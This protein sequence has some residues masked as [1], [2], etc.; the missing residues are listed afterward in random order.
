MYFDDSH[1]AVKVTDVT[2]CDLETKSILKPPKARAP[3]QEVD[4]GNQITVEF[5]VIRKRR[6]SFA[7]VNRIKEFNSE[8]KSFS[9][10]STPAYEE[11][12]STSSDS[13]ALSTSVSSNINSLTK[14]NDITILDDT[15]DLTDL[16]IVQQSAMDITGIK[17]QKPQGLPDIFAPR[18][19]DTDLFSELSINRPVFPFEINNQNTKEGLEPNPLQTK[20]EN[21]PEDAPLAVDPRKMLLNELLEESA[22]DCTVDNYLKPNTL[23][24]QNT[25]NI[26]ENKCELK[27]SPLEVSEMDFTLAFAEP[28]KPESHH[29]LP[30]LDKNYLDSQ[31]K[32]ENVISNN[33]ANL[34]GCLGMDLEQSSRHQDN[35]S[36][37]EY[38]KPLQKPKKNLLFPNFDGDE[39]KATKIDASQMEFTEVLSSK[40]LNPVE[41]NLV[42]SNYIGD[43]LIPRPNTSPIDQLNP[44]LTN[45]KGSMNFNSNS[46]ESRL[47]NSNTSQM[48]FTEAL[49]PKYKNVAT[50]NYLENNVINRP[51]ISH[52]K[53]PEPSQNTIQSNM[54]PNSHI[55]TSRTAKSNDASQMEFTEVL[56]SKNIGQLHLVANN[57]ISTSVSQ[58]ERQSMP[59]YI[60]SNDV[61][62]MEFTEVLPS[63]NIGHPNPVANNHIIT[64]DSEMGRQSIPSHVKSN[65]ASQMEF[66]EVLP[67]KNIGQLNLVANN[68]ISTSV[69]Q[70]G[71]QSLPS[72]I[73]SN[74]ASHMEFTEVLPSKN[75]DHPNSVANNHIIT[76]DS[77]MG[78]PSIPSHVKSNDASQMEFTEVLPSKNIGC[79]N[80]V[81][82]IRST[83]TVSQI[84]QS[85][86]FEKLMPSYG[87]PNFN[88]DESRTAKSNNASQMELTEALPPKILASPTFNI[89]ESGLVKNNTTQMELTEALPSQNVNLVNNY[90]AERM[91]DR[92]NNSRLMP[93]KPS[94]NKI[95]N[96]IIPSLKADE[97]KSPYCPI[98]S[99]NLP[100]NNVVFNK[101]PESRLS[102]HS[103]LSQM[104]D[105]KVDLNSEKL[106]SNNHPLCQV[107][108]SFLGCSEKVGETSQMELTEAVPMFNKF[109]RRKS[110]SNF[111]GNSGFHKNS[112]GINIIVDRENIPP[113]QDLNE[114]DAMNITELNFADSES[115]TCN[116]R[117]KSDAKVNMNTTGLTDHSKPTETKF[118]NVGDASNMEFTEGLP[119]NVLKSAGKSEQK[120]F[121]NNEMTKNYAVPVSVVDNILGNSSCMEFTSALPP[122]KQP[123]KNESSS[124]QNVKSKDE[125]SNELNVS[126]TTDITEIDQH[127]IV[128]DIKKNE[129]VEVNIKRV[130]TQQTLNLV[131]SISKDLSQMEFT[132]ALPSRNIQAPL[133]PAKQ[134]NLKCETSSK[135]V[136][137]NIFG[138]NYNLQTSNMEFTEVLPM[139][140]SKQA[141]VNS[142]EVCEG[143]SVNHNALQNKMI[144][145]EQNLN[146]SC[147]MDVTDVENVP[148]HDIFTNLVRS[149]ESSDKKEVNV[150]SS[151]CSDIPRPEIKDSLGEEKNKNSQNFPF[152][153]GSQ[154]IFVPEPKTFDALKSDFS[155]LE[156]T[157]VLP[158]RNELNAGQ[159]TQ[160]IFG[161]ENPFMNKR[162]SIVASHGNDLLGSS[163]MEFTEFLQ[164]PNAEHFIFASGNQNKEEN[165][166]KNDVISP[167]NKENVENLFIEDLARTKSIVE[168]PI[169]GKSD[170]THTERSSNKH[171]SY[172]LTIQKN[173]QIDEPQME[174]LLDLEKQNCKNLD[175]L[176]KP[177]E[178]VFPVTNQVTNSFTDTTQMDF[179]EA[180]QPQM[181]FKENIKPKENN[182]VIEKQSGTLP[183]S[184]LDVNKIPDA[185]Q[186]EFTEAITRP[187]YE[188]GLCPSINDIKGN[189]NNISNDNSVKNNK[190][191]ISRSQEVFPKNIEEIISPTPSD[192][193]KNISSHENDSE[194]KNPISEDTKRAKTEE[195]ENACFEDYSQLKSSEKKIIGNSSEICQN[196]NTFGIKDE[197]LIHNNLEFSNHKINDNLVKTSSHMI[198]SDSRESADLNKVKNKFVP[199]TQNLELGSPM[200]VDEPSMSTFDRSD[201]KVNSLRKIFENESKADNH[202][203]DFRT[204]KG[205]QAIRPAEGSRCE[206]FN[207]TVDNSKFTSAVVETLTVDDASQKKNLVHFNT[208]PVRIIK[209]RKTMGLPSSEESEQVQGSTSDLALPLHDVNPALSFQNT[210][211]IRGIFDEN[212]KLAHD[213]E[214]G[215]E[216]WNR[217][218]KNDAF[219]KERSFHFVNPYKWKYEFR[220]PMELVLEIPNIEV[221]ENSKKKNISLLSNISDSD[222]IS[223]FIHNRMKKNMSVILSEKWLNSH[224]K[225]IKDLLFTIKFVEEEYNK[226]EPLISSMKYF[227]EEFPFDFSCDRIIFTIVNMRKEFCFEV[228]IDVSHGQVKGKNIDVVNHVGQIS[229]SKVQ[230]LFD[231]LQPNTER[232]Y[233]FWQKLSDI[234][235]L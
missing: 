89:D 88:I 153:S 210:S 51:N 150:I 44:V 87:V 66:T 7:G 15:M 222:H 232:F 57:Y 52:I 63:K 100:F 38:P 78:H 90:V 107:E 169:V 192:K 81:T 2:H 120:I 212:K 86:P 73:K 46:N 185:S 188:S 203:T 184:E 113:S 213:P 181:Q 96:D 229:K 9:I 45:I 141:I 79:H 27:K 74:D 182:D 12:V 16:S 110:T 111:T 234:H 193:Q 136:E 132:E 18:N 58:M 125:I 230:Q 175:L 183:N 157:E 20:P 171:A 163:N 176:S 109:N 187:K 33:P 50:R 67:S 32:T 119:M 31:Q 36:G 71:R 99:K 135:S 21:K 144:L 172:D 133:N 225:T 84:E 43:R 148:H 167:K 55:D 23:F 208:P 34:F 179:T 231:Q 112:S 30:I 10:C 103:N 56:P 194:M 129:N 3:L 173:D 94:Q 215:K 13:S 106:K 128:D 108:D 145:S 85:K 164:N 80:M 116:V 152:L 77:E 122:H 91:L 190:T 47:G 127:D 41:N 19:Q 118:I 186:M 198:L 156:F 195:L 102:A 83:T 235:E 146:N 59:S 53:H 22:M 104:E 117:S 142:K 162:K 202:S 105:L 154:N 17:P 98:P 166:T 140:K 4:L 75:I 101:H 8:A 130:T 151:D 62:Q 97:S 211:Q 124:I 69:S 196:V 168:H 14:E 197:A 35:V 207:K 199:S 174:F 123:G 6:V 37:M 223:I 201:S 93:L 70:M 204:P 191:A 220:W 1:L 139:F 72:Y 159:M 24:A 28:K 61:S 29:V 60:K 68:H 54:I 224:C 131:Q 76:S 48:E 121:D 228:K 216:E 170:E 155:Q 219:M 177:C 39:S 40:N 126:N 26:L 218:V 92:P 226:L 165:E 205:K 5:D 200:H 158:V 95:Q 143:I 138:P 221:S 214:K 217:L 82:N 147:S 64:S 178:K 11:K 65:D 25:C 114:S 42:V 233:L 161:N 206:S 115:G 189:N 160:D 149:Q 137:N 180:M 49:P 227:Y 134:V 209:R